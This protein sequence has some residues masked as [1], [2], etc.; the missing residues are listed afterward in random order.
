MC[1]RGPEILILADVESVH[2]A[3]V[4]KPI[5]TEVVTGLA[6]QKSLPF[7]HQQLHIEC[8]ADRPRLHELPAP[9]AVD[10]PVVQH[11]GLESVVNQVR[12]LRDTGALP[13]L[14][15]LGPYF[16]EFAVSIGRTVAGTP[17]SAPGAVKA[18]R[19]HPYALHRSPHG[20][21][22][23]SHASCWLEP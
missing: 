16:H 12:M 3:G 20:P 23:L 9:C 8:D 5:L 2:H 18:Y 13:L 6:F 11:L 4:R 17:R 15:S 10:V 19:H 14:Y 21:L 7:H 22:I 1:P